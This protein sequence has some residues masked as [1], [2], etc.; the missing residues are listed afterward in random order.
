[1]APLSVTLHTSGNVSIFSSLAYHY[2]NEYEAQTE[3]GLPTRLVF[4]EGSAY[5]SIEDI[6]PEQLEKRRKAA[7]Q[8]YTFAKNADTPDESY[9]AEYISLTDPDKRLNGEVAMEMLGEV[10]EYTNMDRPDI[11]YTGYETAEDWEPLRTLLVFMTDP[12]IQVRPGFKRR[13]QIQ[14]RRSGGRGPADGGR[15]HEPGINAG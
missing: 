5:Q 7:E 4:P 2:L 3:G 8:L 12:Q 14:R 6:P 11:F 10:V 15:P 13:W 1:M 9:V